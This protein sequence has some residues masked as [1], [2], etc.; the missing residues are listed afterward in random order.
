MA[1][2]VSV[3]K[4]NIPLTNGRGNDGSYAFKTFLLSALYHI[5]HY[6]PPSGF[7]HSGLIE[8]VTIKTD[9]TGGRMDGN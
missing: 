2:Q 7:D 9:K 6:R 8:A 4:N 3:F 1:E 5:G